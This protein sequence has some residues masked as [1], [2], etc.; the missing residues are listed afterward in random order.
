MRRPGLFA[1]PE[2][3]REIRTLNLAREQR[4]ALIVSGLALAIGI[5]YILLARLG[6]PLS[7]LLR[8]SLGGTLLSLLILA[9]AFVA[10]VVGHE[11]IHGLFIGLFSGRRPKF[12]FNWLFA[13]A[14]SDAYFS[15]ARYILI[16]LAPVALFG[17]LF[18]VL[19]LAL[20]PAWY[21]HV[22]L[23]QAYN[24]AGA[25]GD[26]YV[27]ALAGRMPAGL[28]V[29]DTGF[30]MTFYAHRGAAPMGDVPMGDAPDPQ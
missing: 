22:Q 18:L 13:W 11:L 9:A 19:A 14:G 12:G 10:Y 3:Y 26:Y 24:L 15:R 16:A 30:E 4:P 6:L 7:A 1:L 21:W 8:D 27:V 20:P 28:L 25:A 17:V 5:G 2:G 23:L 29:R